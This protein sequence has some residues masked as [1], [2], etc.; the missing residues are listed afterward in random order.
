MNKVK[1]VTLCGKKFKVIFDPNSAGGSCDLEKGIMVI[2]TAVPID[3]EETL[4]HECLE[5]IILLRGS[6]YRHY[7]SGNDR[8]LMAMSHAEFE[9]IVKDLVPVLGEI[10]GKRGNNRKR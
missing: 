9:S 1:T 8:I 5:S 7:A 3:V 6:H 4:L 2:G 10:Y